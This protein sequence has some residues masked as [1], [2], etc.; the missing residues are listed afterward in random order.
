[1]SNSIFIKILNLLLFII[2]TS[3]AC[4]QVTI[5]SSITPA[6]GALLDLRDGTLDSN[7]LN[8]TATKGLGLPRVELQAISGDLG[9]SLDSS[10]TADGSLDKDEHIGLVVYNTGK[11]ESSESTRFCPGIHVWNGEKWVPLTPYPVVKP[12]QTVISKEVITESGRENITGT[13][14]YEVGPLGQLTDTRG[15]SG[16]EVN[17]YHYA[18]FY[19]YKVSVS[20][21]SITYS[22]VRNPNVCDPKLA[23]EEIWTEPAPFEYIDDGIWMTENIKTKYMTA[24]ATTPIALHP[25]HPTEEYSKPQYTSPANVGQSSAD[26]IQDGFLYNWAAATNKK[27]GADGKVN[28]DNPNVLEE[29]H[30]LQK[31]RQGICPDGWHIPSDKE[32]NELEAAIAASNNTDYTNTIATPYAWT[33]TDNT[34]LG[35]RGTTHGKSMSSV[36]SDVGDSKSAANGGFNA[37]FAGSATG[38]NAAINYNATANFWSSSCSEWHSAWARTIYQASSQ[39]FRFKWDRTTLYSVRCRK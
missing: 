27:G 24:D 6:K 35:N 1:M 12:T 5:G 11:D 14:G 18:R 30:S 21:G 16:I 38:Q 8:I 19:V 23:T 10:A 7:N 20:E 34:K 29:E 32:W 25:V 36:R 13:L 31:E 3:Y 28:I 26:I 9:K 2:L 4:A 39:V 17:K 15:P 33:A 37:L 22:G